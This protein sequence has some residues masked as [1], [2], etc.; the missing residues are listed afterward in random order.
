[1]IEKGAWPK[2][3][4]LPTD[5]ASLPEDIGTDLKRVSELA[6]R[7]CLRERLSLCLV[8]VMLERVSNTWVFCALPTRWM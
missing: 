2:D 7:V 6:H 8:R 1:M 3:A 4:S 5:L